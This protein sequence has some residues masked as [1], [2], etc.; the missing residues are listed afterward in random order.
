MK[1]ILQ[2]SGMILRLSFICTERVVLEISNRDL[3]L[4]GRDLVHGNVCLRNVMCSVTCFWIRLHE[5]LAK[6]KNPA[7]YFVFWGYNSIEKRWRIIEVC[8]SVHFSLRYLK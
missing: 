8:S 6:T 1:C 2:I 7:G 3:S 4:D 5:I